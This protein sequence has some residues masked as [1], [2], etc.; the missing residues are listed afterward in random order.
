[1]SQQPEPTQPP[2]R[3]Y[4]LRFLPGVREAVQQY[5]AEQDRSLN[6][7]INDLLKQAVGLKAAKQ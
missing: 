4:Q 1:M 7:A 5:A 3:H 2:T 6:W